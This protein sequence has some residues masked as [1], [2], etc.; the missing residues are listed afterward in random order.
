MCLGVPSHHHQKKKNRETLFETYTNLEFLYHGAA[1]TFTLKLIR[2]HALTM[3]PDLLETFLSWDKITVKEIG[4]TVVLGYL[5][6]V[7]KPGIRSSPN[8][9]I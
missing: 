8:K 6:S 4:F 2:V 7:H 3:Y 5:S 1:C 9:F